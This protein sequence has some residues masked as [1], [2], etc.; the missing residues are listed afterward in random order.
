MPQTNYT[1]PGALL[2][3]CAD[4]SA[5]SRDSYAVETAPIAIGRAACQGSKDGLAIPCTTGKADADVVGFVLNLGP[6][7]EL[8]DADELPVASAAT[9]L[10]QGTITVQVE[11]AV[12]K[13]APVF[14]RMVATGGE[15]AGSCR[16]DADGGDAVQLTGCVY[17]QTT[18]AAGLCKIA[19]NR[20]A[21]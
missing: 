3:E 2:G 20:P 12:A 17:M 14:V 6:A 5:A 1:R 8:T 7:L 15:V 16:S 4:L 13:G 10:R 11:D 21:A 19:V 9:V 18:T